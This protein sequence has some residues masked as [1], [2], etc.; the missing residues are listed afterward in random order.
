MRGGRREIART[1]PPVD[2]FVAGLRNVTMDPKISA[3]D[4]RPSA[5]QPVAVLEQLFLKSERI[6]IA[7]RFRSSEKRTSLDHASKER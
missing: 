4:R 3:S 6:P 2:H 5:A 1:S 7:R